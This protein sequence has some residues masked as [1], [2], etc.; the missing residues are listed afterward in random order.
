MSKIIGIDLGTTNSAVAVM[1]AGEPKILEN[2]E[3]ARTTPSIVAESKTKERLVGL[4][5]KR[6]GVTNPKNT[7]YQIK[8]FIG[9]TFD[10]PAVQKDKTS[11]PFEVRKSENGGIEVNMAGKWYRP[12]EISAMILTKLKNDAEARLGEKIT[13]AVITVP[14]YFNV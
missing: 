6:Q 12:E 9:H 2:A 3:G 4:L 8:R 14:A 11:V 5:A 1:E 10:E 7:I 13:E